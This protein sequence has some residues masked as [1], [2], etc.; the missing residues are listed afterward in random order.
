MFYCYSVVPA[1]F[2]KLKRKLSFG[3]PE[4]N[5][6][7]VNLDENLFCWNPQ[8]T[9]IKP[10]RHIEDLISSNKL[11]S[12]NEMRILA[13]YGD[14]VSSDHISPAG[15]IV[16]NS[17]AADY[18]SSKGLVPRQ[19]NSYGSRRGNWEVMQAGTSSHLKLKNEMAN[20]SG[21][22]T[23]HQPSGKISNH[24]SWNN[25]SFIYFIFFFQD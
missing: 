21:P 19:F 25:R 14:S 9:Y 8:S 22:F 7:Q 12:F 15:S 4:W 17:P 24:V 1:I 3:N 2:N 11:S 20:K 16:R 5:S 23:V 6:L 10:P 18:L 13:K